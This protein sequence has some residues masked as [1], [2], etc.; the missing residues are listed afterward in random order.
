MPA[1]AA[2]RCP[3]ASS[4]SRSPGEDEACRDW[5]GIWPGE[6][7]EEGREPISRQWPFSDDLR[8]GFPPRYQSSY[9]CTVQD[10]RFAV[11]QNQPPVKSDRAPHSEFCD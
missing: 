3:E 7:G 1:A 9:N 6:G 8:T 10:A 2:L 5:R 11:D 4:V